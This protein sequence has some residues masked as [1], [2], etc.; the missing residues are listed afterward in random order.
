MGSRRVANSAK[1]KMKTIDQQKETASLV[2][3]V[4]TVTGL[5]FIGYYSVLLA[6]G[7]ALLGVSWRA[8]RHY[9]Q[10]S[11]SDPSSAQTNGQAKG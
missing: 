6:I 7:A 5:M 3:M 9:D 1:V 11:R 10:L 2:C 4:T 8:A